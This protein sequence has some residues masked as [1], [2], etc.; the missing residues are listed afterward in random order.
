MLQ[1]INLMK[2]TLYRVTS[3]RK[4][5]PMFAIS[6]MQLIGALMTE[7]LNI[8]AICSMTDEG[9][10][11]MNFVQFGIIAEIDNFYAKTLK[12]SFLLEILKKV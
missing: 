2:F 12:N 9:D 11:I 8:L 5:G 1:G 7:G 3:W 6:L 4:K 10:I